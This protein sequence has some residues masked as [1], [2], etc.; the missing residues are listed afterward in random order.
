MKT[1][2]KNL[3]SS[4]TGMA[5][6]L[7][8]AFPVSAQHATS[9]GSSG[10]GGGH[11]SGGGGSVS[12]SGGGSH[13]SV[14]SGGGAGRS[15]G[16]SGGGRSS[17]GVARTSGVTGIRGVTGG[18]Q[19]PAYVY[20]QGTIV[21]NPAITQGVGVH[22]VLPQRTGV[23]SAVSYRSAPQIGYG[24]PAHVG[25][26]GTHGYYHFNKGGYTTLY[27]SH[28]GYRCNTLRH[29]Y[30]SFYWA[31][32]QFWFLDGLFY[33]YDNGEYTVVDPPIGAEVDSI[34]DD[35]QSIVINGEQYYECTGVYYKKVTKDDGSVVYEVAGKDGVLNTD[36]QLNDDTPTGPQ[37]GDV[38]SQLPANC[39]K[40]KLNDEVI[41]VSPDGVYYKEIIDANGNK[42]YKIVGL[43]ADEE[44][45]D[46]GTD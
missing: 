14:S 8:L 37:L 6:C 16:I 18:V 44:T 33:T 31:D 38:V 40:I 22:S 1:V 20:H 39:R 2:Y 28:I 21:R 25:Y 32:M 4:A 9:S 35:A 15:S 46:Q 42:T 12:S 41:Y 45:P 30:Y 13:A 19:K 3:I 36:Q 29:G 11:S 10:G 43:P 24:R 27:L 7:F 26:W 17:I 34:C 5:V 23:Y